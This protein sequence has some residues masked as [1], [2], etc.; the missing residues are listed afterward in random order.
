M[1]W[2]THQLFIC[3]PWAMQETSLPIGR[4]I[5]ITNRIKDPQDCRQ[6]LVF[7]RLVRRQFFITASSKN[8]KPL[9][10]Q[11][12]S[13]IRRAGNKPVRQLLNRMERLT[14][15]VTKRFSK[16]RV[17]WQNTKEFL[18]NLQAQRRSPGCSNAVSQI[19]R[20]THS[21]TFPRQVG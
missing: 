11:F 20:R 9:H 2:R 10:L 13:G 7:R 18:S 17:G 14:S 3:C 15:Q 19:K 6:W 16:R 12:E 21:K 1:F 8:R 5:G 4:D